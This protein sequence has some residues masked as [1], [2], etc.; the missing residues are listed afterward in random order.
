MQPAEFVAKWAK[1]K[2]SERQTAQEHFNNICAL[3]GEQTPNDANSPERYAFEKGART[4]DGNGFADVWMKGHSR[5]DRHL[6]RL[7]PVQASERAAVR[8]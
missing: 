1:S 3:L 5:F 7:S 2:G 8:R 4:V 6:D